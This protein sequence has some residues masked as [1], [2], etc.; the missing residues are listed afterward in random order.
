MNRLASV[1][2]MLVLATS[3]HANELQAVDQAAI[4]NNQAAKTSQNRIDT[5]YDEHR[6]ALQDYRLTQAEI[7]QLQV[8]NRQLREIVA[9]QDAEVASL[10]EQIEQIEYTQRGIMPLME[11]MLTGLSKFIELDLPF[12]KQER[13]DRIQNLQ[14]LLLSADTTV[15][16]KFRRVMEAYQIELEYGRTIETYR[17]KLDSGE[18]VDFLRLGRV[19]FY[20]VS[21]DGSQAYIWSKQTSAWTQLDDGYVRSL[22]KGIQVARKQAAPSLLELNVPVA[23]LVA[24]KTIAET[25][26]AK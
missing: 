20:Y 8:Y 24:N 26:E 13:S 17:E 5:L 21:L 14:A 7:E 10:N 23:K 11:R 15:S 6:E 22:Q 9:N 16:E 25:G 3:A 2:G 12:L 4:K 18:L 1:L 19:A